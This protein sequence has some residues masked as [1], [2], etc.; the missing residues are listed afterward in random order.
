MSIFPMDEALMYFLMVYP[1]EK[2]VEM[3]NVTLVLINLETGDNLSKHFL[4]LSLSNGSNA[5]KI[6]KFF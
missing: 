1:R 2:F 6:L 4:R 3:P 5:V